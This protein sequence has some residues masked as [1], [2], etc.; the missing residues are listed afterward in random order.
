MK[1]VLLF[2][3]SSELY[4]APR[5]MLNIVEGLKDEYEFVVITADDGD[6]VERLQTMGIEVHIC[7]FWMDGY[8]VYS[9]IS[10][11]F[12][13]LRLFLHYCMWLHVFWLAL[14]LHMQ[15]PF[16]LVH[17]NVGVLRIGYVVSRIL[18]IPHVWHLREFQIMDTGM[19]ILYGKKY[20]IKLLNKSEVVIAISQSVKHFFE[21]DGKAHLIYNGVMSIPQEPIIYQKDNYLLY[22]SS[23]VESKGIFDV[24]E[25]YS[26]LSRQGIDVPLYICGSGN[27]E[28]ENRVLVFIKNNNLKDKVRVL[29]YR[30]DVSELLR[31]AKALLMSSYNE[32]FGRITV[33]AMFMGCPV[34]GYD[35]AGTHEILE[36]ERYGYLYKDLDSM[37]VQIKS[38]LTD[39]DKMKRVVDA[40]FRKAC[41]E[42]SQEELCKRVAKVYESLT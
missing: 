30:N 31:Y 15:N 19:Y 36:S 7:K 25:V 16:H 23:I 6:L 18:H 5:S 1:R 33:E 32:A 20:L 35:N 28:C 12:L 22:A 4:G 41:S 2:S 40:A 11:C 9:R 21:M 3:H 13:P 8:G 29:G 34:V 42:Y 10:N 39:T 38:V 27:P 24:L 37:E 14:K 17:T 26:R